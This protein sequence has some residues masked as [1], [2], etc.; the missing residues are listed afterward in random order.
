[1]SGRT[2]SFEVL[3]PFRVK[4]TVFSSDEKKIRAL[5]R[6][7]HGRAKS[8]GGVSSDWKSQEVDDSCQA[9]CSTQSV[10]TAMACSSVGGSGGSAVYDGSRVDSILTRLVEFGNEVSVVRVELRRLIL[11]I[12]DF[13]DQNSKLYLFLE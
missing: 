12:L 5:P 11:E 1:M 2:S 3:L 13:V 9:I 10:S 7:G 8:S 6:S 4:Q